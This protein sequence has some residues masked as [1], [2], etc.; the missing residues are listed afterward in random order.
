MKF[1]P[2]N[3]EATKSIPCEGDWVIEPKYDGV[4]ILA[5][6]WHECGRDGV[7]FFTRNDKVHSDT[8]LPLIA[9]ELSRAFP[10]DT[11]LDGEV[12]CPEAQGDSRERIDNWGVVQTVLGSKNQHPWHTRLLY[13]IFDVL[14]VGGQD[15][16]S[17]P[18]KQRR[19]LLEQAMI[20]ADMD[21]TRRI[22]LTPQ[23]PATEEIHQRL[24]DSGWEGSI[25]K[26]LDAHYQSGKRGRGWYKL[27][28]V[29]T[30]E[31]V[32]MGFKPGEN[33]FSGMV[34]AIIFGQFRDGVLTERGKVS[35]FD[36]ALRKAMTDDPDAYRNRVIEVTHEG[37][38]R[39]DKFRFPRFC[40]FRDDKDFQQV[41]WHSE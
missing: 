24:C 4:R 38:T 10:P 29:V 19:R 11:I 34:G 21:N 35:G 17:L 32:I 39:A 30:V 12:I 40:R 15:A 23:Y 41:G 18:L 22:T 5:E 9:A 25:I 7:E 27:K 1:Q 20:K 31:G 33:S 13:V 37:V 14:A 36:M 28:P 6:T 26:R 8:K 2:Q 16:R 3:A